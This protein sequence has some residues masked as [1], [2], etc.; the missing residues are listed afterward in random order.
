MPELGT[1][2][3]SWVALWYGGWSLVAVM[4]YGWDKRMARRSGWR[5]PETR[6]HLLAAIGGVP[7]AVLAQRLFRHK[8]RKAG[9]QFVTGLIAAGHIILV[10]SYVWS[11]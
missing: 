5:I 11:R 8:N 2:P 1:I 7:G 10:I 4:V 3:L 9:F 6:L